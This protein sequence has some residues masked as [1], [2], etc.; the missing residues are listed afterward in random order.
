MLF[1]AVPANFPSWKQYFAAPRLRGSNQLH[2]DKRLL[3][4]AAPVRGFLA[5]SA[6]FPAAALGPPKADSPNPTS[7]PPFPCGPRE[8]ALSP[9]ALSPPATAGAPPKAMGAPNLAGSLAGFP[10][11]AVLPGPMKSDR[12]NSRDWL[13][14]LGY[15]T[16]VEA[17]GEDLLPMGA[18]AT[19][20]VGFPEAEGSSIV[21]DPFGERAA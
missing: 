9:K 13:G 20:E 7:A 10:G 6:G 8:N 4:S 2:P 3:T 11:A 12:S 21:D 1:L 14:L 15:S 5:P 18:P 17:V 19:P 16:W